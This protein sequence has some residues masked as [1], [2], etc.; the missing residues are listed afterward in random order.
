MNKAIKKLLII[1]LVVSTTFSVNVEAS[2]YKICDKFNTYMKENAPSLYSEDVFYTQ[3]ANSYK[4]GGT[5][6]EVCEANVMNLLFNTDYTE[7]D[8][9]D[10]AYK[11]NM[12][13]VESGNRALDGA[14]TP[15]QMVNVLQYMG[16][17]TGHPVKAE[18]KVTKDVPSDVE[19]ANL[20]MS[21]KYMI[22]TVDSNILWGISEQEC[23]N[24]GKEYYVSDHWI[25]IRKPIFKD[26]VL[27]G[28]EI[29]DSSGLKIKTIDL[30][31]FNS[32]IHGPTGDE[33]PYCACVI[34]S[35]VKTNKH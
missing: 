16:G 23:I 30:Q 2:P 15:I 22:V 29:A 24:S 21:G 13:T 5:C 27:V 17:T 28:F 19:T 33:L 25:V 1:P 26:D 11:L 31:K 4:F 7:Q 18:L 12:C 9:V 8:F 3:G 20:L 32:I 34:V 10:L 6:S 14:Q 35:K